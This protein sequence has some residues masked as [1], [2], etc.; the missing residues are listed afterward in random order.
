MPGAKGYQIM[1]K[2]SA[3]GLCSPFMVLF[4]SR[5]KVDELNAILKALQNDLTTLLRAYMRPDILF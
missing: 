1:R 3:T 4:K 5:V 2:V